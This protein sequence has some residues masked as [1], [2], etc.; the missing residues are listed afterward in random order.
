MLTIGA[1]TRILLTRL[2][3]S[4]NNLNIERIQAQ[5][6]HN[7]LISRVEHINSNELFMSAIDP[8]DIVLEDAQ[9]M[10]MMQEEVISEDLRSSTAFVVARLDVVEMGVGEIEAFADQ[11][12]G[13]TVWPVDFSGYD[14]CAVATVQVC[15]LDS[16]VFSPICPEHVARFGARIEH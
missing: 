13:E 4:M 7:S 12:D 16:W 6:G 9:T 1:R 3:Q 15:S 14:S 2:Q 8:I 10:R 11:V 5:I